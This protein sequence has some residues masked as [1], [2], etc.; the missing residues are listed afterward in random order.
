MEKKTLP[1]NDLKK[2]GL[3]QPDN[4]FIKKLSAEDIA[5]FMQ[6]KLLIADNNRDRITFRL[7]DQNSRLEVKIYELEQSQESIREKAAKS[8]QY[9][10]EKDMNPAQGTN[11]E[12]SRKAFVFDGKLKQLSEYDLLAD[13]ELLTKAILEKNNPY[14]TNRY[15]EELLKMREY[16]QEKIDRSPEIA[17]EITEN[18]NIVSREIDTV[19]SI[20]PTAQQ[21]AKQRQSS[22]RL[23][24]NDPDLYQGANAAREEKE[25]AEEQE[26]RRGF[27][28]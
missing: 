6:G 3:I 21:S 17:K 7:T 5:G 12:T 26:K 8:T 16:L 27:R 20:A 9:V 18:L 15:K 25:M 1:T 23:D 2:Y 13:T 14:E 24:V 28:R 4:T 22:I 11:A 10:D 19:N